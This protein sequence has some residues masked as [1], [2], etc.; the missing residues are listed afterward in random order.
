ME[1]KIKIIQHQPNET[2]LRQFLAIKQYKI[3]FTLGF[4]MISNMDD[5]RG[6]P[7]RLLSNESVFYF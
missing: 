7:F 2:Y 3:F 5:V 1:W 6:I 4:F